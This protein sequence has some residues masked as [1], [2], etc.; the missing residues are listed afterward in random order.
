MSSKVNCIVQSLEDFFQRFSVVIWHSLL[1]YGSIEKVLGLVFICIHY[2]V[3]SDYAFITTL[4]LITT[5]T[6]LCGSMEVM[7]KSNL[8][9]VEQDAKSFLW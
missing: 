6:D 8:F 5:M 3:G 9:N 4:D 7:T 1:H 2:N